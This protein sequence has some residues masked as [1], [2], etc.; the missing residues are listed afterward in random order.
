MAILVMSLDRL[1]ILPCMILTMHRVTMPRWPRGRVTMLQRSPGVLSSRTTH[2]FS[3]GSTTSRTMTAVLGVAA[4]APEAKKEAPQATAS[5]ARWGQRNT[6]KSQAR[7]RQLPRC[8]AP[9][10]S[11]SA[12]LARATTSC[13]S[14]SGR[15]AAW[16]PLDS[17]TPTRSLGTWLRCRRAAKWAEISCLASHTILVLPSFRVNGNCS[18]L[19]ANAVKLALKPFEDLKAILLSFIEVNS[20][21]YLATS[22]W[23]L[24][25]VYLPFSSLVP[26]FRPPG[27][28]LYSCLI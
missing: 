3:L 27:P 12:A 21:I 1:D 13:R 24:C 26:A 14:A 10:S 19:K 28:V 22:H 6:S 4:P 7:C 25:F 15:W 23:L 5:I 20:I 17:L 2:P 11:C 8:R 16:Q 9:C 18:R